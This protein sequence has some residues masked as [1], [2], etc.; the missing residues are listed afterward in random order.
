MLEFGFYVFLV[1]LVLL[2]FSVK[3]YGFA[4]L[5][6]REGRGVQFGLFLAPLVSVLIVLA[7]NFLVSGCSSNRYIEVFAGVE[8]TKKLSPMCESGGANDRLTSNLGFAVCDTV[9]KDS[10]TLLCAS[11]R[12]HSCAITPDDQQYDA[13]GVQAVRRIEF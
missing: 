13:F 5:K 9:S 3:H 7:L 4:W 12:H 8:Q 2:G 10:S 6:T 11:Y 1:V